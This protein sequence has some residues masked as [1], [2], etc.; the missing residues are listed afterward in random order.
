[1]F[2]RY[3][4]MGISD[5]AVARTDQMTGGKTGEA[6]KQV[7]QSHKVSSSTNKYPRQPKYCL[8]CFRGGH[9]KIKTGFHPLRENPEAQVLGTQLVRG[10]GSQP[11]GGPDEHV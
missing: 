9:C 7:M 2:Q 6:T 11:F 10:L 4:K 1:M 3:V 8:D 5:P